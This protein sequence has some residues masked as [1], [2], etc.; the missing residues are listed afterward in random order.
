VYYLTGNSP[1]HYAACSGREFVVQALLEYGATVDVYN[2]NGHTPLMEA[3]NA[4]H[5][6]TARVLLKAGAGINTHSNEFKETALTLA[7]Y[8]G[9]LVS[10]NTRTLQTVHF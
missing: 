4:G 1:L 9:K 10:Q 3:A 6:N 2:E 8:K 5:I 7:A